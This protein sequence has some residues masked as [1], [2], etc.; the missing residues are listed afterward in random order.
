MKA[1]N[2]K[3]YVNQS[4][5]AEF[6]FNK[7]EGVQMFRCLDVQMQLCRDFN[8][9]F[10]SQPKKLS[11]PLRIFFSK[12]DQIRRKLWIWSHMLK[13]SLMENFIFLCSVCQTVA[14]IKSEIIFS[15]QLNEP[16]IADVAEIIKLAIAC[17]YACKRDDQLNLA[18]SI[19]ECLPSREE[20]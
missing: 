20:E 19:V 11:F 7:S 1:F 15:F 5:R 9:S 3:I 13:K 8:S 14:F 12:C 10:V 4:C 17:I 6:T 18:F 16:L 2:L